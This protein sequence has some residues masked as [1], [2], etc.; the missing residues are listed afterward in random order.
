MK[1]SQL[2]FDSQ[3]DSDD[4][5]ERQEGEEGDQVVAIQFN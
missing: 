1:F 2:L 5:E 4:D 3:E